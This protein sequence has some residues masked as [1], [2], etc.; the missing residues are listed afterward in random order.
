MSLT[1]QQLLEEINRRQAKHLLQHYHNAL[2]NGFNSISREGNPDKSTI[3]VMAGFFSAA[4]IAMQSLGDNYNADLFHAASRELKR[5]WRLFSNT[6]KSLSDA[7]LEQY[8]H[9]RQQSS[10]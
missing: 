1:N 10:E 2:V 4:G 3:M 8:P 7:I 5:D 6:A 9:M